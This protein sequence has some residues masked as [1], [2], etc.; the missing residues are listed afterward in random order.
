MISFFH[1]YRGRLIIYSIALM[2]FL[3]GT[4]YSSYHH[5]HSLIEN[6]TIEHIERVAQLSRSRL[7]NVRS[8]LKGYVDIVRGDLRLQEYMFVVTNIGSD[9]GPLRELYKKH[10]GWFATDRRLIIARNGT[11]LVGRADDIFISRIRKLLDAT[12][13]DTAY[14]EADD[15]LEIVAVSPIKYRDSTLGHVVL[16]RQIGQKWLQEYHA[17]SGVMAFF[18]RQGAI[19]SSST[20]KLNGAVPPAGG[21]HFSIDNDSFHIRRLMLAD[22]TPDMPRLWFAI[23]DTDLTARLDQ[24]RKTTLWLICIGLTA[25]TLFGLLLIRNFSRPLSQLMRLTREIAAG[26]LPEVSKTRHQNEIAALANQFSDMVKALK[27]K[28]EEI[29]Q[30]HATLEKS[31]ITDM[32]TGLYNRRYLQVVFPK[33]VAQAQ[34]DNNQI[35]AILVDIDHFKHV[36]DNYG[37]ITGDMCLAHF[38]DELKKYSRANDYLFRIGGEEFLVLSIVEDLDGVHQFAE[39]LRLAIAQSPVDYR[40]NTISLTISCGISLAD[41]G[42]SDESA[43]TRLLSQADK[44]LYAA[45][46]QGRNRVCLAAEVTETKKLRQ[47]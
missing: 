24:H 43:I 7:E 33:L 30:V 18:E 14:I 41:S 47:I 44:A 34:R 2:I 20:G 10:F 25:I 9:A 45:K 32:L 23:R 28:Q 36:N 3:S 26:K 15:G 12:A 19:I 37:H 22:T 17:D 4:L 6:E 40:Q 38:S 29:D 42:G 8:S 5:V 27:D 46:R 1:S 21:N 13:I 35:A 16:T 11:L 39:K 31:A